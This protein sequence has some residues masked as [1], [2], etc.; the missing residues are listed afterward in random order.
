M[1]TDASLSPAVIFADVC[2][3]S[4][5]RLHRGLS[6][7]LKLVTMHIQRATVADVDD[8]RELLRET[9]KDTYAPYLAPATLEQVS[10]TWHRK[11]LLTM[12]VQD[13]NLFFFIA[14][15]DAGR[16]A[17]LVNA[18]ARGP[19][20]FIYRLY[21]RPGDQHHGVGT[22][23]LNATLEAFPAAERITLSVV[24]DNQKGFSFWRKHGFTECGVRQETVAGETVNIT[25]MERVLQRAGTSD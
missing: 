23:L 18:Q 22:A 5:H 6:G 10:A 1:P 2:L 21:V 12:R 14:R 19:E 15:D 11:T 4:L 3:L 24:A 8:I 9:W 17:G 13:P 7:R 25:E 16:L 20:L